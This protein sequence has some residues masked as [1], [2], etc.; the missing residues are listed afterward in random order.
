MAQYIDRAASSVGMAGSTRK[1]FR[2]RIQ[3]YC[4]SLKEVIT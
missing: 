4:V 2:M 1:V 3:V